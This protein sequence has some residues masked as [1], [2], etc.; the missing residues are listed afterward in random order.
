[1]TVTKIGFV[2]IRTPRLDEVKSI[3]RD[4]LEIPLTFESSST[5]GF[6]LEN[7]TKLELY[8]QSDEFHSFFNTGPVVGFSVTDFEESK[9][10]M[11]ES[12]VEFIGNAQRNDDVTWQHFYL[13]DGTVAEIIGK[14]NPL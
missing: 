6:T 10:R 2:G 12:G 14:V 4:C 3:F 13:P 5:V 9:R 1:M 11:I 8:G 7:G